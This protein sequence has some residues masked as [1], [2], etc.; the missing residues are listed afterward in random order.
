MAAKKKPN[1]ASD[2]PRPWHISYAGAFDGH[3]CTAEGAIIAAC[4]HMVKDGY[5]RATITDKNTG[6]TAWVRRNGSQGFTVHWADMPKP[7]KPQLRRVK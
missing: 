4:R 1:V 3:A 2:H 6:K 5:T 7:L